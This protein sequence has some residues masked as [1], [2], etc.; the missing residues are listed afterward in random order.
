MID[1][2]AHVQ[3]LIRQLQQVPYLASK[4]LYRVIHYL[5][6]MDEPRMKQFIATLEAAH[7][8]TKKCTICFAW[9]EQD[10]SCAWCS[11]SRDQRNIC[12]VESWHDLCAIEK[13]GAHQGAYHVLGGALCPLDGIGLDDLTIA[14]LVDRVQSGCNEL[15]LA[16]N[17]TPEGEATAACIA[18]SLEPLRTTIK[19]TC[20]SRGVPVGSSLETMDRLTIFKAV[21]ER[22][23]F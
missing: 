14:Q 22:R 8:M 10:Q 15:I 23:I 18:R 17:Q 11:P 13:T 2:L 16:M 6:E 3:Q 21:A 4:N 19:I 12:V 1:N 20:L 5:L 7:R 9:K